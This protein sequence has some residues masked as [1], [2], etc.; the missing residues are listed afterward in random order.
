[1]WILT[2][3]WGQN[4]IIKFAQIHAARLQG[5]M[6]T[7]D[8]G[9]ADWLNAELVEKI[10]IPLVM[11]AFKDMD[12][13]EGSLQAITRR[14]NHFV[15]FLPFSEEEQLVVA[16]SELRYR[17]NLYREP[18]VLGER[19]Y[20]NLHLQHTDNLCEYAAKLYRSSPESIMRGADNMSN[21]ADSIDGKFILKLNQ[22]L[23]QGKFSDDTRERICREDPPI[24]KGKAGYAA[25]PKF[26]AHYDKETNKQIIL[27]LDPS[28]VATPQP[29]HQISEVSNRTSGVQDPFLS[30]LEVDNPFDE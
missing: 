22:F 9:N 28:T 24:K 1:V 30:A 21:V 11:E 17:F 13:G 14:I 7:N 29:F 16:D 6:D 4:E 10:L 12:Y 3:N 25:E 23:S 26:W 15:P 2:A 5:D 8:K 18:A 19:I 20:G 27:D